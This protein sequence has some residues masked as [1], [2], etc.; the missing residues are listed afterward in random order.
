LVILPPEK[1]K[2]LPGKAATAE[3][4]YLPYDPS[5]ELATIFSEVRLR[6]SQH[7]VFAAGRQQP[8][9]PPKDLT[10]FGRAILGTFR[11]QWVRAIVAA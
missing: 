1:Q 7:Y 10:Q 8:E 4:R 11:T 9:Q 6:G 5:G 2:L 3:D